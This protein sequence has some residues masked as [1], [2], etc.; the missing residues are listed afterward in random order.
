MT[1]LEPTTP[2]EVPPELADHPRYRVQGQLGA[3]GM[4]VVYKAE[5]VLMGRTVAVKVMAQRFTAN[6][7]AVE[8]FRREVRAA[9]KLAHPNIVTAYDADE[10]GGRHFLVMEYVEGVSLDRVVNRRGPLPVATACHVVRLAALGLQHAHSKG[11]VHRDIKPQNVMVNR[12]S[13]VK[14]LDFGLARLASDGELPDGDPGGSH[15]AGVTGTNVVVGTPDYVSPEQARAA[16]VDHRSDLYS[17]GCLF[18]FALTGRA[19]FAAA[20]TV[21]EKVMAHA[22]EEPPPVTDYRGDLPPGVVAILAKMMAKAPAERYSSAS[23]V[24]AA[25][26]PFAK[27]SSTPSLVTAVPRLVAVP[28]EDFG[29][30]DDPPG[31]PAETLADLPAARRS[32][33]WPLYLGLSALVAGSLFL[34]LVL[35]SLLNPGKRDTPAVAPVVPP[36]VVPPPVTARVLFVLPKRGLFLDDYEPVRARLTELGAKVTTAAR[37][38]GPCEPTGGDRRPAATADLSLAEV[39]PDDYDAILFPGQDVAEFLRGEGHSQLER[40]LKP[41]N[42]AKKVIGGICVGQRVLIHFQLLKHRTAAQPDE[43][44][45]RFFEKAGDANWVAWRR[46]VTDGNVVTATGARDACD[47]A[48]AVHAAVVAR[49]K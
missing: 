22:V 34:L 46:V 47:F 16:A 8:R 6:A 11:M 25:L 19:P 9:A 3:G 30:V 33:G 18:Y 41:M 14:V 44:V 7:V 2:S 28:V 4:G 38:R 43:E 48:E 27:T 17:L 32:R 20:T 40:I 35:A 37:Q 1:V 15:H 10:A 12:K 36:K 45:R 24:A 5:H 26:Q 23:D 13:Q 29:F 31:L 42:E 21:Y 39:R 49:E